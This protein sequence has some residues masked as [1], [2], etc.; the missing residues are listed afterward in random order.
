MATWIEDYEIALS[1]AP[2]GKLIAT[3]DAS[4]PL[5]NGCMV[6]EPDENVEL[7][8]IHLDVTHGGNKFPVW[9]CRPRDSLER[10]DLEA[11]I[12]AEH[13]PEIVAAVKRMEET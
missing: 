8:Y 13:G 3:T 12:I 9:V 7:V 4:V 1:R 10:A 2:D 11:A 5:A 6:G